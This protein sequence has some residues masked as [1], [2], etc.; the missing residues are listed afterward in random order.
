M[1]RASPAASRSRLAR[2]S[3]WT[4]VHH[5]FLA[6]QIRIYIWTASATVL[7]LSIFSIIP[8]EAALSILLFCTL[9]IMILL[10]CL[11]NWRKKILVSIQ[12]P[13]LRRCAHAAMLTLIAERMHH[14]SRQANRTCP[15]R[16]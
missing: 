10:W 1:K 7:V 11:I 6:G 3:I 12:D 16:K 2:V 13:E 4:I 8:I 14:R 9:A 15:L 5:D